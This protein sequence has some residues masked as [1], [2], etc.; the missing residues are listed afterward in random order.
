MEH[1]RRYDRADEF[2]EVVLGHWDAWEDDALIVDKASGRFGD[3]SK[4]HRLDYKGR[5]LSSR[6]PSRDRIVW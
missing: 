5:F 6:G 2:V 1:D 3:G 4:V